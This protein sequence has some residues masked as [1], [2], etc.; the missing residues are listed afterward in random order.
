MRGKSGMA[1]SSFQSVMVVRVDAANGRRSGRHLRAYY[2]AWTESCGIRWAM[3]H[4]RR[5]V[6]KGQSSSSGHAAG[7]VKRQGTA[8]AED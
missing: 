7:A 6:T 3:T 5:G 4:R 2:M 8:A 1:A